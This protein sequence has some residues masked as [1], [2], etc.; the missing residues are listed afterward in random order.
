M[1]QL[2]KNEDIKFSAH[3]AFARITFT[4]YAQNRQIGKPNNLKL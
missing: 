2:N 1:I 3:D 4:M